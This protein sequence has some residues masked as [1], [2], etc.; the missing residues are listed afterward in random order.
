MRHTVVGARQR[1]SP[2][3]L[4]F[5]ARSIRTAKS[6]WTLLIHAWPLNWV[7]IALIN[8]LSAIVPTA[9]GSFP[10]PV[11]VASPKSINLVNK[12]RHE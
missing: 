4:I 11:D 6:C 3:S 10:G 2:D 5:G 1:L 9:L 7:R 12:K 8:M